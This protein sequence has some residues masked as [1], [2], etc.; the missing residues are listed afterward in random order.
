MKDRLAEEL[1]AKVMGWSPQDIA[2]YL[3]PLQAMAAYKY[4]DYQQ[5]S[6]G[7]RFVESLALWLQQFKTPEERITAFDFVR[8]RLTFISN[9]EINHLVSVSYPDHVK[10]WLLSR[11]AERAGFPP[12]AIGKVA[13]ST[14]FRMLERQTLFL[15]LSDGARID[16]FRR[17]NPNL[18]H[19][20]IRQSHELSKERVVSLLDELKKDVS[21]ILPKNPSADACKFR[22]IILIDDFS[23]TG[24]S[25]L[26][27]DEGGALK[28]KVAKFFEAV[29]KTD[30]A[31]AQLLNPSD[32][33]VVVMLYMATQR[34]KAYLAERVPK[35][36][37][38]AGIG[39]RVVVVYE[40]PESLAVQRGQYPDLDKIIEK[41]YDKTNE[42]SSTRIGGTD[43]KYGFSACG[44]PLVLSHN[45]PNNS[46]GLLWAKGPNMQPLFPRVTRH[47]DTP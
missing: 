9:A 6:A 27:K 26:R 25:Y 44:L 32:C 13:A 41:Y 30:N 10:P 47:K 14:E 21:R 5:F 46:I 3:P 37:Y 16:I 12:W 24:L 34:A 28:G 18:S 35:L 19:E 22:T 45:T 20:Q 36:F 33:H 29:T 17:S 8:T 7:M 15:G 40:F 43:L 4:D 42:D 31:V 39:C 1:L 38:D 2:T 23:G 11:A